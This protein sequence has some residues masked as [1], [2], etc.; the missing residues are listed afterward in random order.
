MIRLALLASGRGSNVEAILAA[1]AAGQLRADPVALISDRAAAPVIGIA[2]RAGVPVTVILRSEHP[3]RAAWDEAIRAALVD[4]RAQ[5][6]A[7]AGFA[8]ILGPAV[9]D[10][11]PDRILNIHPSL[12]PAFAGGIAPA[13]QAAAL[14]SGATVTGCTVHVVT[15]EVDHGPI[16]AQAV[17]P[18]LP[19]D[20]VGT[21][22]ERILIAEHR[23]YPEVIA[24][25][26]QGGLRVEDRAGT[27][28]PPPIAVP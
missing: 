26:A 25:Y 8:A 11:Y 2:R 22:S 16:L 28:L 20:T 10:A 21:L 14:R 23:L 4:A 1:I 12:L 5:L 19:E 27:P 9:L 17:V 24:R 3:T 15:A 7:L 18:I 13:P 6:V